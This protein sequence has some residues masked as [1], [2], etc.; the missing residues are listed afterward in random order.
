MKTSM[1]S[2]QVPIM[3]EDRSCAGYFSRVIFCAGY[4][5]RKYVFS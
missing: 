5:S 1:Q 2:K 4:F 3:V